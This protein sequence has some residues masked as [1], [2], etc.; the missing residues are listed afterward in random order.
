MQVA[1]DPNV[2]YNE[3]DGTVTFKGVRLFTT[4][5]HI[6]DKCLLNPLI[7]EADITTSS[8]KIIN[9]SNQTGRNYKNGNV[10]EVNPT[11]IGRRRMVLLY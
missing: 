11:S 5:G 2:K 4:D 6:S 3:E 1:A 8:T 7:A 9:S 10:I